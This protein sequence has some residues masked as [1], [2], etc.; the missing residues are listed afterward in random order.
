MGSH[1]D[2]PGVH[3]GRIQGFT[4]GDYRGSHGENPGVFTG[5]TKRFTQDESRGLRM[6]NTRIHTFLFEV[7]RSSWDQML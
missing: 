2:N 3:T 4:Q 7:Y 5:R 6:D 1:R